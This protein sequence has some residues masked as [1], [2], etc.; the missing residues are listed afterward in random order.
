MKIALVSPYDYAY[1][2]GVNNHVYHLQQQFQKMGHTVKIIAPCSRDDLSSEDVYIVGKPV[3]IPASGSIVRTP[4]S[5]MLSGKIKSILKKENFDIVHIHEPLFPPVS[6]NVLRFSNSV[7]VGTFHA[8][9]S[10]SWGYRYWKPLLK[11]WFRRLHGKIAVSVP[12][13]KFISKY[14]PA[15]YNIIPNGIEIDHFMADVPKLEQ[16]CDGKFNILFVGRLEKRKGLIYL[17]EAFRHLKKK[18]P[19][20]RLIIA[21]PDGGLQQ[22][23]E[24]FVYE[25]KVPDVVFAGFV[26]YEDLPRYYHTADVFCAPAFERESF[27]IVLLEAMAS[28][29][30]IVASNIEGYASVVTDGAE[31]IL[32]APRNENAIQDALL[33]LL[34]DSELRDEIGARGRLKVQ[35]YN[36]DRVAKRIMNYYQR[37]LSEMPRSVVWWGG[38]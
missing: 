13:M 16:F 37:L 32:V 14:F 21:G 7:N 26:S 33:R 9:R 2:G 38:E 11:R 5:P 25:Y 1:P 15:Y 18:M 17:L 24:R 30:P 36:W 8:S 20:T 23:Y 4:V 22:G 27:G 28:G 10:R 35:E 31:A 3:P 12:A 6:L 19:N 29:K 34:Q